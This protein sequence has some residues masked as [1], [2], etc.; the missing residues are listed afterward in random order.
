MVEPRVL[1]VSHNVFS[2]S[3]NMGKTMMHMAIES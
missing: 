3:G 2:S 1:V